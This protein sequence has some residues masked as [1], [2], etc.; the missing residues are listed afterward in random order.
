MFV[1]HP[2]LVGC[3]CSHSA[4]HRTTFETEI[5]PLAASEP[6]DVP[7]LRSVTVPPP[8]V[9]TTV[10][11]WM[12]LKELCEIFDVRRKDHRMERRRFAR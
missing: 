12:A 9:Q 2:S 8:L 10:L 7:T 5:F 11:D 6:S 1:A 3:T 4:S